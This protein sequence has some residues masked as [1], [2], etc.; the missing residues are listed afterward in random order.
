[1]SVNPLST[2][3]VDLPLSGVQH[4]CQLPQFCWESMA[5]FPSRLRI[6]SNH[7]DFTSLDTPSLVTT[8]WP[9]KNTR[10]KAE[11]KYKIDHELRRRASIAIPEIALIVQ[12]I[13]LLLKPLWHQERG[14]GILGCFSLPFSVDTW[15]ARHTFCLLI[16]MKGGYAVG[17]QINVWNEEV[18]HVTTLHKEYTDKIAQLQCSVSTRKNSIKQTIS[19]WQKTSSPKKSSWR[20]NYR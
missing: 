19:R 7:T 5:R 17:G 8:L 3:Y 12:S 2:D 10:Y 20:K 14:V 16:G 15:S 13:L 4:Q 9:V 18:K 11:A 6:F 1:M